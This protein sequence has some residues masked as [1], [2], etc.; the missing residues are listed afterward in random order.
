MT[1]FNIGEKEE[2]NKKGR[3]VLRRNAT[4]TPRENEELRLNGS[5]VQTFPT[6]TATERS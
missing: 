3:G 1:D 5:E 4:V 2:T 6:K